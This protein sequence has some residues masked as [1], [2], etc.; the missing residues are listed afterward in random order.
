VVIERDNVSL[1]TPTTECKELHGDQ[2]AVKNKYKE[3]RDNVSGSDVDD[4][5]GDVDQHVGIER[6]NASL[7]TAHDRVQGA[8]WGSTCG[9]K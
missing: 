6:D 7:L 8:A 4:D 5:V 3:K 1:L 2:H 9:K